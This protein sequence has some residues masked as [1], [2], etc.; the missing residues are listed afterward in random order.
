MTRFNLLPPNV[1]CRIELVKIP[2]EFSG[3]IRMQL[4]VDKCAV[5]HV[6]RGQMTQSTEINLA[7]QLQDNLRSRIL[8][9]S[10]H[11][12]M[13]MGASSGYKTG[14]LRGLF[15]SSEILVGRQQGPSL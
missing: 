14:C 4:G 1:A 9:V 5:V 6:N 7:V 3:S 15:L 2:T 13:H 12:T 8:P 10:E 11:V